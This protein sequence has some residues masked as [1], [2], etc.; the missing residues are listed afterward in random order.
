MPIKLYNEITQLSSLLYF[1]YAD[2]LIW[3]YA[4]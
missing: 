1:G 4:E 3:E 2:E